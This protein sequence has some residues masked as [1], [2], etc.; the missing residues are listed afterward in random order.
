EGR[1][2]VAKVI[3]QRG[4]LRVGDAIVCGSASGHVK[5]MYDTLNPRRKVEEAGPSTPVN[6]TGMDVPPAAGDKFYVLDDIAQSR[7]IAGQRHDQTRIASLGTSAPTHVTL[8]NLFDRLGG[9]QVQTLNII[10]R[11]DVRGSIEAILKEFGKLEHPEVKIKVLQATV[12][13]IS[14]ADI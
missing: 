12:G 11:A 9:S 2:V 14:E 3:V 4:T 8:E 1:G 13:G 7:E 6:V 5:A 10:L